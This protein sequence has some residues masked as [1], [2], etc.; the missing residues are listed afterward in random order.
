MIRPIVAIL[1]GLVFSCSATFAELPTVAVITTGGTIA[2]KIDPK[3]GGAVPT[4]SGHDLVATVTDLHKLADIEVIEVIEVVNIDSSQMTPAIWARISRR[5]D[6]VLSRKDVRGAVVTHGT[7]TMSEGAY[8]MDVTL[9]S[10]KPVVF[11]GAMNNASSANPDGPQ[12]ILNAVHQVVSSNA[13]GWGV[14]VTLN[15][16]INSARDVR[17]TQTTN[18]QTFESGEAGY[19]GYIFAGEVQ[20]FN[21]RPWRVRVHLPSNEKQALP[22]VPYI[23][24]YAGADGRFVRHAVDSGA[25]GLV[26][27]AVGAG[28]VNADVYKAI[29]YALSKNIPVV[30]TSQVYYGAVEPVY[31]DA[32]GGK[33]LMDKGCILGGRSR[34]CKGKVSIDA[35]YC[36]TWE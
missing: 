10:D 23:A 29:E 24:T 11:T 31:G 7:D 26:V 16:Y 5:L 18:V 13:R 30:I 34:G 28:N 35:G 33:T 32:G 6:R 1:I 17:K 22:D 21:D 12:N 25:Q 20:R 36:C 14:T 3:T 19:L 4:V 15:S 8:F 2:Q 27:D 9:K